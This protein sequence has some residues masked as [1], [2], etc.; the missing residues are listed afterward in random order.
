MSSIKNVAILGAGGALG[1]PVLK[2]LVDSGKFSIT[3]VSRPASTSTFA[4]SVKVIKADYNSA[5]SLASAFQN[6]DAVVSTVGTEGLLGQ[7]IIIDAAI[8]AGVKRILPSEFGSDLSN[9]K[10]AALPVFGYKVATRKHLEDKI[11]AGADITYTYVINSGFLDWGLEYNFL[12]DWRSAE[13]KLHNGGEFEFSSTTLGSVG[14]AV[15]GVLSNPEETK[16]RSVYVQDIAISQKKLLDLARKVA[17]ERKWSPIATSLDE[18]E[19]WANEKLA[20]GDYSVMITYLNVVM[21]QDGYGARFEK[22]DNELLG[23]KGKT[24]ADVEDIFKKLLAA[25]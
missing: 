1:T 5:D 25:E 7:S 17:P 11:A 13:P 19:K 6:Q 12:L 24:E 18:Q 16:N 15:V 10:A 8:A 9:P 23:V 21:F 14:Q 20:A 4:S 2:A 3:V 22:V